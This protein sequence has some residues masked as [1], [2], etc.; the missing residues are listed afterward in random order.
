MYEADWL[1]SSLLR[2]AAI[3]F[4]DW[5]MFGSQRTAELIRQSHGSP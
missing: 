3:R 5:D 4:S 2:M 1:E